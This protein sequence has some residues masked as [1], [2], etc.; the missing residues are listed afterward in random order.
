ME[1]DILSAI[2]SDI[3]SGILSRIFPEILATFYLASN[4]TWC[5]AQ[6]QTFF[7]APLSDISSKILSGRGPK[8]TAVVR[9][10]LFGF[11]TSQ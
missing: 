3:L 8:E 6:I 2:Y 9:G 7:V 11:D 10:S 4:L 5:V 1:P